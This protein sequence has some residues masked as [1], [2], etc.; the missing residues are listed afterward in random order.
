MSSVQRARSQ[1]PDRCQLNCDLLRTDQQLFWCVKF[2]AVKGIQ[3]DFVA[4]AGSQVEA[5]KSVTELD[6]ASFATGLA[7]HENT[8]ATYCPCGTWPHF[9]P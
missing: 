1:L 4:I 2:A 3:I 9:L 5:A 7:E 8:S 6:L